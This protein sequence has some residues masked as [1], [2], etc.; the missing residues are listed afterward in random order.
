MH[1]VVVSFRRPRAF[2]APNS[3]SSGWTGLGTRAG[4]LMGFYISMEF[5]TALSYIADP[6]LLAAGSW[7]GAV[8]F[9]DTRTPKA[10][11]S[12]RSRTKV[13]CIANNQASKEPEFSQTSFSY[14][15]RSIAANRAHL[16]VGACEGRVAISYFDGS[17]Q[18]WGFKAHVGNDERRFPYP[19]N[20]MAFRADS[21]CFATGG[22]DGAVLIWDLGNR[23]RLQTLG[24]AAGAPFRRPSHPSRFRRAGKC[25]RQPCRTAMNSGRGSRRLTASS[26]M[27]EVPRLLI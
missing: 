20:G 3:L 21:P 25:S 27:N 11:H 6:H 23:K 2:P 8:M 22:S 16:A 12:A 18:P 13:L 26:L 1:C 15:T 14:W 5:A 24:D 4:V 19:A 7:D 17:E 10:V 9:W